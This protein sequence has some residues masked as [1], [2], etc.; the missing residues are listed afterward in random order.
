M[1]EKKE[2]EGGCFWAF[3]Y[4]G[5]L[6]K[7]ARWDIID[8]MKKKVRPLNV[9]ERKFFRNLGSGMSGAKA[10]REAGYSAK[11]AAEIA[12]ENLRKPHIQKSLQ[13]LMKDR[14][15]DDNQV[16]SDLTEGLKATKVIGYLHDYSRDGDGKVRKCQ[17]D[18]VISNEFIEVPDWANRHKYLQTELE[19]MG[20][21]KLKTNGDQIVQIVVSQE[22]VEAKRAKIS[23]AK[24]A[25]IL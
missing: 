16:L 22:G 23:R 6:T 13:D 25:G 15:L 8:D 3:F 14:G 7:K 10:A 5:D 11:C 18:E 24:T 20:Y 2:R 19:L 21:I 17:P 12:Y 4:G 9:R 1:E